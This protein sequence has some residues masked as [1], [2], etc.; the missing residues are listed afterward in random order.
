MVI[1]FCYVLFFV[2]IA[3]MFCLKLLADS[4]KTQETRQQSMNNYQDQFSQD[5]NASKASL[6][7]TPNLL[8]QTPFYNINQITPSR[9]PN[10]QNIYSVKYYQN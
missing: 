4:L 7:G 3:L 8:I 9:S 1:V 2:K 10:K 5:L 6:S